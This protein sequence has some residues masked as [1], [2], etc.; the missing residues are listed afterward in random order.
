MEEKHRATRQFLILKED[1][2]LGDLSIS[3]IP[4]L[5]GPAVKK[6]ISVWSPKDL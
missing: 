4:A 2:F 5:L 3:V 6:V 1:D